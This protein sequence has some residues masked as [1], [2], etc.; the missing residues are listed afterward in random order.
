MDMLDRLMPIDDLFEM[1][2]YGEALKGLERMWKSFPVPQETVLNSYLVVS[3]GA[4]IALK[5]G[6][7][8]AAKIWADR[9]IAYSGNVNLLGESEFLCGEVAFAMGDIETAAKYFKKARKN[10]G[11][12]L[13]KG[14]NPQYL[15]LTE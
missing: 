8:V 3:Y 10:S 5:A 12:R 11:K 1:G 9:N 7:L 2:K 6:D 15:K 14:Q 4:V 13:F